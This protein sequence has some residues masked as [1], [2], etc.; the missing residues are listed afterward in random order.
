M[1]LILDVSDYE[2]FPVSEYAENI[3]S[4]SEHKAHVEWLK[5]HG[6]YGYDSGIEYEREELRKLKSLIKI[7]YEKHGD[8]RGIAIRRNE[9]ESTNR[10]IR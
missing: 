3:P 6:L 5:R 8:V 7:N 10:G 2:I 1:A 9:L 4:M